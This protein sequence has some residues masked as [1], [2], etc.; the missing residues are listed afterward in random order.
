MAV[1][2]RPNSNATYR[3]TAVAT[4]VELRIRLVVPRGDPDPTLDK[5]SWKELELALAR[6][7][8][9]N[10]ASKISSTVAC[11]FAAAETSH[12][13]ATIGRNTLTDRQQAYFYS[14]HL[15]NRKCR[16]KIEIE[17]GK[18]PNI[19]AEM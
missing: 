3:L 17:K 18:I 15:Q 6:Y 9:E 13:L 12:C 16:L 5:K 11:A 1:L 4:A 7:R 14:F 2:A 19:N 8:I 10:D